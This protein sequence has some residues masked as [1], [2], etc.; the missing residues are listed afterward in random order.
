LYL[1]FKPQADPR[2]QLYIALILSELVRGMS[3]AED[4]QRQ[5]FLDLPDDIL[6][7]VI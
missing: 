1:F 2:A 5:R 4:L 7:L 6:Q 3:I